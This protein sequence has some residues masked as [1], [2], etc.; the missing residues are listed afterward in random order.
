VDIRT[1]LIF[2]LVSVAIV[3]MLV[4]GTIIAY[5]VEGD[6]R[7]ATLEELDELAE[8]KRE[9]LGW[10]IQGWKDRTDLVASRTQLRASLDSWG[11]TSDAAVAEQVDRILADAMQASRSATL[12]RVHDSAGTIVASATRGAP[13]PLPARGLTPSP[14]PTEA[15]SYVG[16]EFDSAGP[17]QVSFVAPMMN[18]GRR[19]GTLVAVFEATE[20]SALTAQSNEFGDTGEM[21]IVAEDQSGRPRTLHRTRHG[22]GV[23]LE[24]GSGGIAARAF[25]ADSE[26]E[27][28]GL[29]DYRGER[30]WV[31]TRYVPETGWGVVVKVDHDEQTGASDRFESWLRRWAVNLSAFAIVVGLGLGVRFAQPIQA[32]AEV[33]D[34]IRKGEM[35]ARA[36]VVHEDEVG[37]LARTFNE[38]ASE[39]EEQMSLLHEFRKFFDVSIDMM[40]IASTD[41]YFKRTNPAFTRELGWTQEQLLDRPFYDLV[42][43][44]DV[45]KT[46]REVAKLAKGIP[47]ISFENRFRCADGTYKLLRWATYPEDGKLYAIAHVMHD[48]QAS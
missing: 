45:A 28:E 35:S 7:E 48:E 25:H 42:H 44:E 41:G 34:R 21:L 40:C 39:L 37:L 31:A 13:A 19:V 23:E 18:Q 38:M 46:E 24:S 47:T 1:K 33:A 43:P 29:T 4:F 10:I 12:F 14:P 26:P 3:S 30:V 6:F 27:W 20:L 16:V 36:K 8:S 2:A 11:R 17:S 32:L 22:A 15:T 9:A 5:R